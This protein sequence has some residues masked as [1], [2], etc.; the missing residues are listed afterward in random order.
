[1][2]YKFDRPFRYYYLKVIRQTGT[3]EKIAL[4]MAIGVFIGLFVPPTMQ[5][6]LALAIA[7]LLKAN[8]LTAL[9]G[10]WVSNPLTFG[11]LYLFY[12][13]LGKYM[14]GLQV[15]RFE[16]PREGAEVWPFLVNTFKQGGNLAIV[17]F[18]GAFITAVL[19][20]IVSYYVTRFLVESFRRRRAARR[21]KKQRKLEARIAETQALKGVHKAIDEP[22]SPGVEGK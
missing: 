2:P 18:V 16:I 3:P 6:V 11:P 22:P 12:I 20:S 19:G 15:R 1:M 13:A 4:G 21:E 8:R 9:V 7:I 5:M 17:F 14:T 10:C